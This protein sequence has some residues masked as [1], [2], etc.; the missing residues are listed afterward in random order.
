MLVEV[1]R[2]YRYRCLE[3][4]PVR[5]EPADGEDLLHGRAR[6]RHSEVRR[7]LSRVLAVPGLHGDKFRPRMFQ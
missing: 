3:T 1:D 7:N 2:L 6:V 5:S 4:A